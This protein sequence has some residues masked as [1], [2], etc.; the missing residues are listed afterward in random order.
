MCETDAVRRIE[1]QK[2]IREQQE[3]IREHVA[4]AETDTGAVVFPD[5]DITRVQIVLP[6]GEMGVDVPNALD[7]ARSPNTVRWGVVRFVD[8]GDG[9]KL[10]EFER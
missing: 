2:A 8:M 4:D 9:S 3:I 7:A 5:H 10:V 1:R 6:D